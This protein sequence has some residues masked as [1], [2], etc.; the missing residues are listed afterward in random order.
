MNECILILQNTNGTHN[1]KAQNGAIHN[2]TSNGTCHLR[3][4]KTYTQNGN[5]VVHHDSDAPLE[6]PAVQ[7]QSSGSFYTR[8]PIDVDT[9]TKFVTY[10][11]MSCIACH[12][13]H[14]LFHWIGLDM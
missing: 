9:P 2:G 1:D 8:Q 14:F 5:G 3:N 11:M 6:G 13:M 10:S 4:G 7:Y 12:Y